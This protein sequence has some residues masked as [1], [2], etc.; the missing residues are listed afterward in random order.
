[1]SY[2][3]I[4]FLNLVQLV[5][6]IMWLHAQL[7]ITENTI[8]RNFLKVHWKTSFEKNCFSAWT[9][10]LNMGLIW[11]VVHLWDMVWLRMPEKLTIFHTF[12]S[13]LLSMIQLTE[14]SYI[15]SHKLIQIISSEL[16]IL[17]LNWMLLSFSTLVD[18][19]GGSSL[20]IWPYHRKLGHTQILI[21]ILIDKNRVPSNAGHP[22]DPPLDLYSSYYSSL[23]SCLI[24][25][26]LPT[27]KHKILNVIKSTGPLLFVI[28]I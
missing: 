27:S 25:L 10:T 6:G 12:K 16:V 11:Y 24:K 19:R 2:K 23:F 8:S 15:D 22:L 3:I 14:E 28:I 4:L 26:M 9:G 1:M 17:K 21:V 7:E 20:Q 18:L 5:V 13:A